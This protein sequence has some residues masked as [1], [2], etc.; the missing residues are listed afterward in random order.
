MGAMPSSDSSPRLFPVG[1]HVHRRGKD[2]ERFLNLWKL[3]LIGSVTLA[4]ILGRTTR[5]HGMPEDTVAEVAFGVMLVVGLIL[6]LYLVWAPWEPGVSIWIVSFDLVAVTGFLL[7]YVAVD[8]AIVA[9]NSQAVFFFYFFV[10]VA[11]GLRGEPRVSRTVAFT[12]PTSYAFVI[13]M[14]VAWRHVE[15][16]PQPDPLYGSF[17][18]DIQAARLIILAVVTIIINYDVGLVATDRAEARTDP[19]TGVYNRRF[20]E[21]F[22]HREMTR[23]RRSRLPLSVLMLDLD[24][25]KAFNDEFGHLEG[26]R[27]LAAVAASLRDAVRTTD[28]VARYGGDEFVVVLPNTPGDAA[29]RVAR[30]LARSVPPPVSL[31]VGIGCM[32]E[33]I[34]TTSELFAIADAALMSAKQSG[35]GVCVE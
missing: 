28:V 8:R 6:Q 34:Q 27:V 25:F 4:L 18:W 30:D 21:E 7:G 20:L 24:G 14:A 26:D 1:R 35:G 31:S 12:V 9:T 22:L 33:G 3:A 17:R 32:G 13:F 29:R 11:A 5:L 10:V 2:L 16:M 23:S 15:A 19:L